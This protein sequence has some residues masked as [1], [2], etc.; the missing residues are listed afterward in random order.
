MKMVA[1]SKLNKAMDAQRK[2]LLFNEKLREMIGRLAATVDERSHPLLRTVEQPRN[3]LVL[4]FTSDKGLCAGFN[5]NLIRYG[6]RWLQA[7]ERA[8]INLEM[9]FCGRRGWVAL[10]NKIK[11]RHH[12]E[13]V[14]AR[15]QYTDAVRI[16]NDL[17]SAFIAGE[18]DEV[19]MAYNKFVNPLT[20]RPHFE[21][22]LPIGADVLGDSKEKLSSEMIL[23]PPE[24]EILRRLVPKVVEFEIYFALLENAAGEN[25][26]RMTAMDNATN[27]ASSLIDLYTLMRNRAR[28]ASITKELIEIVSGAE[29]LKG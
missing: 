24:N 15:P 8:G 10:R 17:C 28:Q 7:P 6:R 5:N 26:A 14:T 23:E 22:L 20:Q 4:M 2:A 27:N 13:G 1:A 12:Y 29:A 19:V 21:R 3:V 11:V 16:A 25:G 9:S 18:V